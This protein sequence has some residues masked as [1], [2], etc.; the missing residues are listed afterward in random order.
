[1]EPTKKSYIKASFWDRVFAAIID[2][3]IVSVCGQILAFVFM[4][5]FYFLNIKSANSYLFLT[6]ILLGIGYN[7]GFIYKKG[8]TIGKMA[9]KIK[10]V[11]DGY[12]APSLKTVFL[13]ETVG[14]WISNLGFGLG[15][16]WVLKDK[17]R[18]AWHDKIAH[19]YVVKV[20]ETHTLIPGED[21]PV[22]KK[23]HVLF[24]IFVFGAVVQF[25]LVVAVLAFLFVASP[26]RI[27]DQVMAPAI[28]ADASIV[29]NKI[30]YRFSSPKRGDV[31]L[32]R[33]PA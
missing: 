3:T 18:Q 26:Y 7:V 25:L 29:I 2:Q 8:A 31:I 5:I 6:G 13:R 20:N 11:T 19:T 22:A 23:A 4:A 32:F 10:V 16:L 24:G 17:H 33:S 30:S 27:M 14:K 9:L 15:S 21:A 12:A 1:M 28:P